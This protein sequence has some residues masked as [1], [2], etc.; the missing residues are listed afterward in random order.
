LESVYRIGA[1]ISRIN[2]FAVIDMIYS[3]LVANDLENCIMAFRQ[4]MAATHI[5]RSYDEENS[6][7]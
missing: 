4:T 1:S 3:M 6:N 2:Q 7:G 5:I